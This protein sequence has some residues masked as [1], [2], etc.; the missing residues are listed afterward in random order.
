MLPLRQRIVS[1]LLLALAAPV[2]AELLQAYLAGTGDLAV[3]AGTAA[4][5]APLYGGAALLIRDLSVR[6]GRGWTGVLLLAAA[7]G[8]AMTGII[9]LSMFG[10]HRDD[11]AYWAE[12][13]EPTLV[14]A[15]GFSAYA[16]FSWVLGHVMMSVGA[17]LAI[18]SGLAPR[19][20]GRPLLGRV[21]T[22]VTLAL[23]ALVAVAIHADGRGIYDYVPSLGQVAG[24]LL[25]IATFVALALSRLGRPVR[26]R[27]VSPDPRPISLPVVLLMGVGGKVLLDL[28]PPTWGGLAFAL[29][30]CL[31]WT[32]WLRRV[33]ARRRWG[34]RQIAL[35][36]SALVVAG[37]LVG[38]L[39]PLPEGVT[40]VSKAVQSAVLLAAAI[41]VV[42][43]VE[44]RTGERERVR[45]R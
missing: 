16:T 13:R 33:T 35:T 25:G 7:F 22:V 37:V 8:L 30:V 27:P 15:A 42:V 19:H 20:A 32:L 43:L 18:H 6:T 5:L 2:C 17:P 21:G 45:V 41:A 23:L 11:V 24:V 34:V 4:F 10:E 29:V 14:G 40:A 3:M 28:V 36:G 12:L 1:I 39:A 38:L 31:L 26:V 9:D 44:R